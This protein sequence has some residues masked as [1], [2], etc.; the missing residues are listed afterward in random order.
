MLRSAKNCGVAKS[1]RL[2]CHQAI[3]LHQRDVML[4]LLMSKAILMSKHYRHELVLSCRSVSWRATSLSFICNDDFFYWK[5]R[6]IR[7]DIDL[8]TNFSEFSSLFFSKILAAGA[9]PPPTPS[10]LNGRP[11]HLIE[12]AKRGRFDQMLLFSAPLT[13]RAPQNAYMLQSK[14]GE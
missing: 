11:Q 3:F 2:L 1:S 13:T 4:S 12:A 7:S 10:P 5:T 14:F 9:K 6:K 8:S